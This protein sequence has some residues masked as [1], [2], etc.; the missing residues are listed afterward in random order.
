M[1]EWIWALCIHHKMHLRMKCQGPPC[2]KGPPRVNSTLLLYVGPSPRAHTAKPR[3][4]RTGLLCAQTAGAFSLCLIGMLHS[5]RSQGFL[6]STPWGAQCLTQVRM[7]GSLVFS[8]TGNM[9]KP[10]GLRVSVSNLGAASS[11]S[12]HRPQLLARHTLV[13]Y[14]SQ[15]Q[16]WHLEMKGQGELFAVPGSRS[17]K[18]GKPTLSNISLLHDQFRKFHKCF[19]PRTGLFHTFPFH[20]TPCCWI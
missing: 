20:T 14:H 19:L 4:N 7:F 3:H 1:R 15:E 10:I 18:S 5:P 16:C 9:S 13:L 12:M 17:P 6:K 8:S 11:I 2:P